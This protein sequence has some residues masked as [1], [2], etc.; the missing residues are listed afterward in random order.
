MLGTLRSRLIV[1]LLG[2]VRSHW[3]TIRSSAVQ[4]EPA[5][6]LVPCKVLQPLAYQSGRAVTND[7][8]YKSSGLGC[9]DCPCATRLSF[10]LDPGAAPC[11]LFEVVPV[12]A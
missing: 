6:A 1:L 11:H 2:L 9:C 5:S 3:S 10:T 4:E 7:P 8:A 12:N